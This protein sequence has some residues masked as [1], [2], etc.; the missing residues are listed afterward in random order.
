MSINRAELEVL[1]T[2]N[3][4]QM[5]KEIG[6]VERRMRNY[7]KRQQQ[8]SKS[9][10]RSIGGIFAA[11]QIRQAGV[12]TIKTLAGFEFQMDKVAAVSRATEPEIKRLTENAKDL[13]AVSQFTAVEIGQLQE[14]L[15]RLGFGTN[16]IVNMTDAARKLATVADA[17]LGPAAKVIG[18]QIN[19]FGLS[20]R[21][22]T[23]I[24]NVMAESFSK[25]ALDMQQFSVGMGYAATAGKNAGFTIEQVTAMMGALVDSGIEGSKAGTALRDIFGDISNKGITLEEALNEIAL[26][27]NKNK[28]AFD[29][30]G[31]TSQNAAII[32]SETEEKVKKLTK[33]FEDE[34]KEME[35]MVKTMEGNLL[36]DWKLFNSAIDGFILSGSKANKVLRDLVQGMT[37]LVEGLSYDSSNA[38]LENLQYYEDQIKRL[39]DRVN[40][41]NNNPPGD[42]PKDV[43]NREIERSNKVLGEFQAIIKEVNASVG[44][45]I[46]GDRTFNGVDV[47]ALD[48][49]DAVQ[50]LEKRLNAYSQNQYFELIKGEIQAEIDKLNQAMKVQQ[51]EIDK[52][53]KKYQQ[54]VAALR[55]A[56]AE[57]KA[58]LDITQDGKL[59]N[60]GLSFDNSTSFSNLKKQFDFDDIRITADKII[61]PDFD[62]QMKHRFDAVAKHTEEFQSDYAK[63]LGDMNAT[64]E[65]TVEQAIV[66]VANGLG[67]LIVGKGNVGDIFTGLLAVVG[68][69]LQNLGQALIAYGVGL[70]AF[71]K[72]I[73]NPFAAIAAGTLAIAAGA[74]VKGAAQNLSSVGSGGGSSSYGGAS[75]IGGGGGGSLSNQGQ[76]ID[77][78]ITG[79]MHAN[80]QDLV[81][82]LDEIERR[83][84]RGGS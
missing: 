45:I 39:T 83:Q 33:A 84:G 31:K 15:A 12:H 59:A 55:Q 2:A 77:I 23:R 37:F 48:A 74:A 4:G 8:I 41:L 63:L 18:Q 24:A 3:A 70:D 51:E 52:V 56:Q 68:D 9:I 47:S 72:A 10:Q 71:K 62:A 82:V 14:E 6:K 61:A 64:V 11:D 43:L 67:N 13:G 38:G 35:D 79:E 53:N 42:W 22:S 5:I 34:V 16:M 7:D 26:S 21:D 54:Q 58:Y 28:T 40:E 65:S 44:D 69:G 27:T 32:L 78:K 20:A 50:V 46:K 49:A 60:I 80:G 66:S 25:S 1:M 76:S 75:S 19:A 36:T 73:T 57:A 81:Y 29:L 30:F 17:E